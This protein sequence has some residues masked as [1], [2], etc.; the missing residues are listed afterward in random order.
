MDGSFHEKP[1]VTKDGYWIYYDKYGELALTSAS[2]RLLNT[3]KAV[4]VEYKVNDEVTFTHVDHLGF[5]VK[6]D[7]RKHLMSISETEAEVLIRNKSESIL[8]E[9]EKIVNGNR[10]EDYGTPEKC[11]NAIANMWTIYLEQAGLRDIVISGRQACDMMILLK[12]ARSA[13]KNKR[14]NYVDIAGYAWCAN[15]CNE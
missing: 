5:R 13:N 8:Q 3:A 15:E 2:G 1:Y 4:F 10:Q 12:V 14:D 6:P 11:W 7:M 9:A